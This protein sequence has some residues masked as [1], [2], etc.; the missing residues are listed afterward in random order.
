MA[1]PVPAGLT[2]GWLQGATGAGGYDERTSNDIS[3]WLSG[4]LAAD[5]TLTL[6]LRPSASPAPC[7]DDVFL[8]VHILHDNC[9]PYYGEAVLNVSTCFYVRVCARGSS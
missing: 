7:L 5:I 9:K 2:A 8:C 1:L 3:G 4:T 6:L